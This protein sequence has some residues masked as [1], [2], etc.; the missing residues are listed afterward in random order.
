MRAV[1]II[2]L[3]TTFISVFTAL[4]QIKQLLAMKDSDE[5][6]LFTWI[7]WCLAQVSA[8]FYSISIHSTPY[9]MVN[10]AWIGFYIA[11]I[12]LI[13]KYR[14]ATAELATEEVRL[15]N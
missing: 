8:L 9:L 2:Y 1:E 13:I 15:E 10:I 6:N 7:A 12:G 5:F 3:V 11:M 14:G 4:P